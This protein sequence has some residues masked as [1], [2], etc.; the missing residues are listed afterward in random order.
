M[1]RPLFG[2]LHCTLVCALGYYL[3]IS[4]KLT[5][6]YEGNVDFM[7][8]FPESRMHAAIRHLQALTE[9]LPPSVSS[10]IFLS[11]CLTS[12]LK[13]IASD[14]WIRQTYNITDVNGNYWQ[15][16]RYGTTA[17][18]DKRLPIV[19]CF[20]VHFSKTAMDR[21][22]LFVDVEFDG[23]KTVRL[24]NTHLESLIA[25][26]P[27]RPAQMQTCASYM[28][29]DSVCG[30]ILAGD[31]NATQEY[32]K[33]LHTDNRL[34]DAYLERGGQE[35]DAEAGHTWGQQAATA[36]RE[37]FGTTRMDKIYFC[38]SVQ[39]TLFERFGADV[40]IDNEDERKQIVDAGFDKP[41][42]TDH[43][44]VHAMFELSN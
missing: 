2:L 15:S 5:T 16:D 14:D 41:W 36:A 30:A 18:I 4:S 34:K 29:A 31:L 40:Q 35:D 38:G 33:H 43:L 1:S 10:I 37:R 9:K 32:D 12:D 11:E 27:L 17:L 44:G 6:D 3:P 7:L 21:D 13:L 39:C 24:C 19:A 25:D 8:P 22:G 42:A 23:G 26:P 28:H 20:R